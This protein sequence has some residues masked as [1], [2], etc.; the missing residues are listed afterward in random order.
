MTLKSPKWSLILLSPIVFTYV[1]DN[2]DN[3]SVNGRNISVLKVESNYRAKRAGATLATVFSASFH[4]NGAVGGTLAELLDF[5]YPKRLR[6]SDS[7]W[8]ACNRTTDH[9]VRTSLSPPPSLSLDHFVSKR[10]D[11][12]ERKGSAKGK[13]CGLTFLQ[14]HT[15]K[16]HIQTRVTIVNR[17]CEQTLW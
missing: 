16:H 6:L 2:A 17:I 9:P 10:S 7:F 15:Q 1:C 12:F 11:N 13:S 4:F 14:T 8:S 5:L 3:N